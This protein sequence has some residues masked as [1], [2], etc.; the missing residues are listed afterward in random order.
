[1]KVE[2]ALY[3]T[4]E[5]I[6]ALRKDPSPKSVV[7]L[8]LLKFRAKAQYPDGRETDLTGAQN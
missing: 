4:P 7:M 3:P 2:N 5:Q 1:M 8:N 6:E